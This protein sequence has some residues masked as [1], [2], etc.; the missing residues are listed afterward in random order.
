MYLIFAN[1]VCLRYVI[2][3]VTLETYFN[4]RPSVYMKHAAFC[5]ISHWISFS[6]NA[7]IVD[8]Q[9][10][11]T[12]KFQI[13]LIMT[14]S[15]FLCA[16]MFVRLISCKNYLFNIL[17]YPSIIYAYDCLYIKHIRYKWLSVQL[18]IIKF[19]IHL[20]ERTGLAMLT[21]QLRSFRELRTVLT[22]SWN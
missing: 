1:L 18:Y 17:V 21:Q 3:A 9:L 15:I 13:V 6:C 2:S 10:L 22:L 5:A 11:R 20:I 16:C 7:L 8:V 12:W 4:L 19:T 14:N